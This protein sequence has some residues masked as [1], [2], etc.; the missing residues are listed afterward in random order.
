[1]LEVHRQDRLTPILAALSAIPGV[2]EVY[3][4]DF[5]STA[6]NVFIVMDKSKLNT[7]PYRLY[8]SV[9][10]GI[11]KAIYG[12][13]AWSLLDFPVM[14]YET[15]SFRGV[16]ESYRKGYDQNDIKIEVFI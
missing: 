13:A 8:R 5:D 7:R 12:L 4:D 10:A 2:I 6:V 15:S 14:Q 11:K 16:R 1:M 3:Q 9:K